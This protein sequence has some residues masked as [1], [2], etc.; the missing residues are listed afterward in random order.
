MQVTQERPL[1][2][3]KAED[4]LPLNGIDYVEFY[5]GNARQAAYYYRAAFGMQLIAYSGPE[6]GN[7][8][9]ASYVLMQNRIRFVFTTP[10]KPD[11]IA[12]ELVRLHG[13]GVHD[14]GLLVDD[15]EAAWRAATSRG[16]PSAREPETMRDD[17][18][19]ARIAAI[20]AYGDTIHSFVERSNYGGIFLPGFAEAEDEDRVA[21]PVGLQYIDHIVGNVGW[22]EMNRWVD[23]YRD[24]MGFRLYQHFDDKDIST[25]YSA[26]MSKVMSNGNGRVKFPDQ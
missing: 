7:R 13:D 22:G 17:N 23:F 11:D 12:A 4:F 9:R 14:I 24:T 10:L 16:A 6:T 1:S 20:A 3:F 25:E 21:R 18:G 5:V 8:T 19:E 2:P 15:A 26:L